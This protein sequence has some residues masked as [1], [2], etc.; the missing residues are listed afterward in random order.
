MEI[1][2]RDNV[3]QQLLRTGKKIR[4]GL[5]QIIKQNELD[6]KIVGVDSVPILVFGGENG[7]KIKTFFTQ[8]M[9]KM[10]FLAGNVIYLSCAHTDKDVEDY[11][12]SVSKIFSR[13]KNIKSK[14]LFDLIEGPVCHS[15]FQRLSKE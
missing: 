4:K 13:L 14:E 11:L 9:L 15:G 8:E 2:K 3:S 12:A 7:L 1:F 5:E 10:G 6:I